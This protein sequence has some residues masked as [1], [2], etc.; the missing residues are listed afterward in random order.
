[1]SARDPLTAA[2][3]EAQCPDG[4]AY[5]SEDGDAWISRDFEFTDFREAFA[6][7]TR[8]AFEAEGMDHHPEITNVYNRV[9]LALST[10]DA[11][12]QVTET[13]LEFARRINAL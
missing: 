13:D 1:M 2:Q 4:W 9:G 6:F 5:E 12:N 11:D 3:A 10:H 8:V 7:L